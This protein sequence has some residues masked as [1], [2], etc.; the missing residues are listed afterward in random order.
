MIG[1][2]SRRERTLVVLGVAAA[3]LVVGWIGVVQPLRERFA[4]AAELV[5]VRQ[6]VLTQRQELIAQT[7]AIQ[8]ELQNANARLEQLNARFFSAATPAVAASEL[9]KLVKDIAAQATTEVRSERILTP[10]DR[11]ELLEIPLEIAVSAEIRQLSDLLTRLEGVP[12]L[13][14]VQDVKIRVINVSQPRELL[15]TLTVSGFILAGKART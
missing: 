9:Q 4:V 13:L 2:L 15:A 1:N 7:A 10:V 11:G 5:P 8:R 12:K 3:A 6:Q 14:A